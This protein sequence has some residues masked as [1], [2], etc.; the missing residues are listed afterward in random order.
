MNK[1]ETVERWWALCVE[2]SGYHSH[3]H[4]HTH[5]RGAPTE[6]EARDKEV[7]QHTNISTRCNPCT[8]KPS[9]PIYL[10][11]PVNQ[12]ALFRHANTHTLANWLF[13]L[14]SSSIVQDRVGEVK[15]LL[16]TKTFRAFCKTLPAQM[17]RESCKR[18]K[19][20][21][22]KR[23]NTFRGMHPHLYM[24]CASQCDR[25]VFGGDFLTHR[26]GSVHLQGPA[27][28]SAITSR[29]P[30]LNGHARPNS[31]TA[32]KSNQ[33]DTRH[34]SLRHAIGMSGRCVEGHATPGFVEGGRLKPG[35]VLLSFIS[36]WC[37]RS[38]STCPCVEGLRGGALRLAP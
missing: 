27:Q 13:A 15:I 30:A 16:Q 34:G 21:T 9:P 7:E 22:N 19:E 35:L 14:C 20:Q 28:L 4:T 5:R 6:N 36:S 11:L 2:Q 8:S 31:A 37:L 25:M 12:K 23:V 18:F 1:T 29:L 32:L 26:R 17:R 33:A 24:T 38:T 10:C 3:T